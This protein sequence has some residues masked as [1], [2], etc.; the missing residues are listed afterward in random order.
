M[1][2]GDPLTGMKL[3][4][5]EL[6]MHRGPQSGQRFL[7]NQPSL[8]MGRG[9]D[10]NLVVTEPQISRHHASLTWD[11]SHWI[12]QDLGSVNGTYVNG[13]R[14]AGPRV[15]Q[16]GDLL[17]LGPNVLFGFQAQPTAAGPWAQPA[18]TAAAGPAGP[19][20]MPAPVAVP[21]TPAPSPIP[22]TPVRAG[23]REPASFVPAPAKQEVAE[24]GKR[25]RRWVIP[26]VAAALAL[27]I[28]LVAAAAYFWVPR[29]STGPVVLI[30]SPR[31][32]E[33][34]E[35]GQMVAVH[36]VARGERE[37]VR[38]ELWVDDALQEAQ[39]SNLPEGSSPFPLVAYWQPASAGTH[40]LTARAFN[41][42]GER[43]QAVITV[44]AI[45]LVDR[46]GDG[47][48]DDEDLCPDEPG[49]ETASGCP[50]RDD[51]GIADA[52]DA[53][54]D[55]R[56]VPEQQGCPGP[57]DGD[58]DGD[59]VL[60][61]E[62]DCPAEPGTLA[63][64]GCPDA[65]RD[66]VPDAADACPTQA[67][68]AGASAGA[69]CP[70]PVAGDQDG[71]GV[72]D[73]SDACPAQAGSPWAA[74]CPDRDG[75]G[76]RDG[77]DNCPDLAG[78]LENRGCPV[79]GNAPDGDGDGSADV[80]DDCPDDRG[81]AQNDGC[82]DTDSDGLPDNQDRDPTNPG[83]ANR[84][85]APDTGVGDSDGDGLPDD[86]D[87]CDDEQGLPQHDG[88]PP[89]A[90][91]GAAEGGT[92]PVN[93]GPP[94]PEP[95]LGPVMIGPP[96][97]EHVVAVEFQALSFQ[98]NR[99]YYTLHCYAQLADSDPERYEFQPTG[100]NQW[101]IGAELGGRTLLVA[102]AQ[103]VELFVE[104]DGTDWRATSEGV[105]GTLYNLGS[106]RNQ[107]PRSDWTGAELEQ[108]IATGPG[109][110]GFQVRY[111]LCE[112][113]CAAAAV[114]PPVITLHQ[115]PIGASTLSW[116]WDAAEEMGEAMAL[117]VN[118]NFV[119]PFARNAPSIDV[120]DFRPACGERTELYIRGFSGNPFNPDLQSPPSNIAVWDS[121]ACW[122]QARIAFETLEVGPIPWDGDWEA[123]GPVGVFFQVSGSGRIR[124]I[125]TWPDWRAGP[126]L[127][128]NHTHNI[129]D[130]IMEG[131]S[132]MV[133][134]GLSTVSGLDVFAEIVDRD[135]RTRSDRIFY[136]HDEIAYEDLVPG[137]RTMRNS[138]IT[139]VYS[140]ELLHVPL[141]GLGEEA[142]LTPG[143]SDL[144]SIIASMSTRRNR[145]DL[146]IGDVTM[147]EDGQLQIRI[148]N[149]GNIDLV[150]TE[151]EILLASGGMTD[152]ATYHH[153]IPAGL[154]ITVPYR[155]GVGLGG[156]RIT[157][158]PDDAINELSE[159]NNT[160]TAPARMR[161]E[162]LRVWTPFCAETATSCDAGFI[163]RLWAG[164]GTDP[165]HVTWFA[166]NVRFPVTGTR[167]QCNWGCSSS[168]A[169]DWVM[170]GDPHYTFDF[171]VPDG[172]NLY[173]MAKGIEKDGITA[174]DL[175]GSIRG[176]IQPDAELGGQG[177]DV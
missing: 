121:G 118:D 151:I 65:D 149:R 54:P 129:R 111:R 20:P 35:V 68:A 130:D 10:N 160:F 17:A 82:P 43:G 115:S 9:Q 173:V 169:D 99:D 73:A 91:V 145:P 50:D 30:D 80:Q 163:Y 29:R 141:M 177:G 5:A 6:T 44:E 76:M 154:G 127:Q 63:T 168:P 110:D 12:L 135:S 107:H 74:G 134:V 94:V 142:P 161:V 46:D 104:C 87:A 83:P 16:T 25:N 56:G 126:L 100:Q 21:A 66:G 34:I 39:E 152:R 116:R 148:F 137:R 72:A 71:D 139:L 81:L 167:R 31:Q 79:A 18:P 157:V 175:L 23:H 131:Q 158:D 70:A 32:G 146:T 150:D 24:K 106:F 85:G 136:A 117:Y 64:E 67:G 26:A 105:S 28:L 58:G 77:E 101:D 132:N 61:G 140:I 1:T 59:G 109:V 144:T 162:F 156:T 123:T 143:G 170:A 57:T 166:E 51:D 49:P 88:C 19:T 3:P 124:E 176:E 93:F 102:A 125:R 86:L 165:N 37:V 4:Y 2:S 69:G 97:A 96:V 45:G 119:Y 95:G 128:P 33:Q 122:N 147:S 133:T 90:S 22:A 36:S 92:P 38:V 55:Q 13:V 8:T 108:T 42:R 138:N 112:G 98:T 75:D 7:V 155:G 172:E 113:S 60:D 103:T 41:A 27:A 40:S 52:K 171:D 62:D 84:G 78:P 11:G 15:L 89:P 153:N 14:V 47:V 174:D 114:P 164:H 48:P 53:C 120:T 159:E